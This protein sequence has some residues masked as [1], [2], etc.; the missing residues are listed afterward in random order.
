MMK[1]AI[2]NCYYGTFP[3][4]Y[5]LWLDSCKCNE[6]FDFFVFTDALVDDYCIPHNV[7]IVNMKWNNL[8]DLIQSKFDFQLQIESPYKL[9]DFKVAY[10][11][12]FSE[13][14]K[15]YDYWGYCDV[16]LLFGN[17]SKF[18]FPLM[19]QGYEK[20]YRLGHLTLLKNNNKLTLL[21]MA[22]GS[23]FSY[24]EVFSNKQFYS[25]DEHA[26]LM[27]ISR[28]NGIKEYYKEEM[29][30]ISCRVSRLTVS[31][32]E[33]YQNQVFFY[34]NGAVYRAYLDAK[35][36]VETDEFVYIHLQKRKMDTMPS[37][38]SFYILSH[39][40]VDKNEIGS[41]KADTIVQMSGNISR[42][43]EKKERY[44]FYFQKLR[45]FLR[46]SFKEKQIWIKQKF[47]EKTFIE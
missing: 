21:F 27:S 25:F 42:Q 3:A 8:I 32:N 6:K 24:K 26:G 1:V 46:A 18:L 47:A 44:S 2:I 36:I 31:R 20:I 39:D 5:Q 45:Q 43:D 15:D 41:P 13:Y 30:D 23:P 19:E 12:I 9:T 28:T 4:Y 29:A 11:Y 40:F 10:G 16:D 14:L 35:S 33:N 7:H 22:S 37:T 38:H 17:L 34:E